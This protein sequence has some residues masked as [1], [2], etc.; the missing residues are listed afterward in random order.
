MNMKKVLFVMLAVLPLAFGCK[1]EN[2]SSETTPLSVNITVTPEK[3]YAGDAVAFEA[4]VTGGTTPFSYQWLIDETEQEKT[5]PSLIY[6]FKSNGSYIVTLN[7]TDGKGATAQRRKVVVVDAAKVEETGTLTINWVG[8]M[9]GYNTKSTAAVAN[10]GSVYTTC[11]DNNLYKWSSTG[12]SVWVKPIYTAVS[13]NSATLGTPSIDTD[14]TVFIGAGNGTTS[15]N[16]SGDGTLK[17]FNPDGSTKWTF[18]GWWRSDG[19]TPAP[20]CQGT[21]VAIDEDN[22]YFGCTGQNGIVLSADKATG[23]RKGFLAPAGGARSGI[24]LSQAGYV[25]WYGGKYGIFGIQQSILDAGGADKLS[26][27]WK[28]FGSGDEMAQGNYEGQIACLNVGGESCVAG[29]VT[30]S[31]GTKVYALKASDGSVV[32]TAYIDDTDSQDQGGVAVDE[33]GNIIASLNYTLGQD[34]GGVVIV[35]PSTGT[36]VSRYRTQEKVSGSPAVDK[37]GNIHFGTESGFYY[38]VKQDGSNCQ[39]LV[40]RN[41]A[42]LILKDSRYSDSFSKLGNAKIWCSP[43]IGDDGKMY[44][45]FTDNDS[46][47]FGGVICLSYEGCEGP[48]DS[49]WPMIG[50]DRRHTCKQ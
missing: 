40:K 44:I 24:L 21:I 41:I 16:A 14:G 15:G 6:T 13:A 37:A 36:V 18:S 30:D 4:Q 42:D 1:P 8:K 39:L 9:N 11:R 48:A 45:C 7:V 27:K 19:T 26:E 50:H 5:T 43:V 12:E 38:I 31:R 20:T 28:Q 32:S 46:R 34:N 25:H 49:D 17:A 33:N 35:N 10:D 47:A 22:I 29:I 2:K 23:T 3:V